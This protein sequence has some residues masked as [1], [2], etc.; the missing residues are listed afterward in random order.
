[1]LVRPQRVVG[2][3]LKI[4]IGDNF[5][6]V[7]DAKDKGQGV[8]FELAGEV[9]YRA[10]GPWEMTLLLQVEK[11]RS[12]TACREFIEPAPRVIRVVPMDSNVD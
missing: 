12:S 8:S 3:Q 4:Q 2:C 6:W 1:M 5:E 9:K 10:R 11:S 7:S